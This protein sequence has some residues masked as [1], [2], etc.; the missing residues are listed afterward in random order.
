MCLSRRL[1]IAAV[2][3]PDVILRSGLSNP[4]TASF[5]VSGFDLIAVLNLLHWPLARGLNSGYGVVCLFSHS[6]KFIFTRLGPAEAN[7]RSASAISGIALASG[8]Q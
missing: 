2:S 8:R 3:R 6:H 1:R 7:R 5:R 4:A